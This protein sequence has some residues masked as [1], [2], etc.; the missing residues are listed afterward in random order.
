MRTF[1][2]SAALDAG[3]DHEGGIGILMLV[4]YRD[5]VRMEVS[6]AGVMMTQQPGGRAGGGQVHG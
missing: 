4:L 3:W 6:A 1:W 2:N 5:S